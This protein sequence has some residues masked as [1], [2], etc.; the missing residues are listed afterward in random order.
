M[1]PS[2]TFAMLVTSFSQFYLNTAKW[3]TD[4]E[5][6]K[7]ELDKQSHLTQK[8]FIIN[9]LASYLVIILTA[10]LYIPF[11]QDL[12][13]F[14]NGIF[15]LDIDLDKNIRGMDVLYTKIFSFV[16]TSQITGL[17][18]DTFLPFVF[19]YIGR[20]KRSGHISF[21]PSQE[22]KPDGSESASM[23]NTKREVDKFFNEYRELDE[24]QISDDYVKMTIQVNIKIILSLVTL[25]FFLLFGV[26]FL[27]SLL[28]MHFLY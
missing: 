17:F 22:D 20:S 21:D 26:L 7:Y 6:H 11:E 23:L 24:H 25:L 15:A 12:I 3:L 10:G 18:T 5:N 1:V 16:V 13:S 19:K 14:V 4:I 27:L 2:I 28:S 9:F 8:T